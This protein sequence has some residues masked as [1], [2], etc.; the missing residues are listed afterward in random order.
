MLTAALAVVAVA[1]CAWAGAVGLLWWQQDRMIFPGWGYALVQASG[2]EAPDERLSVTAPD[3]V[4]LIGALHRATSPSRGLLLVFGGN[5]EDADWRL[6][7]FR[8]WVEDVD[9]ATFFYRGYGPSGGAPS[10][11]AL[12]ADA[13]AIHDTLVAR[14][15]PVRVVAAG[16]SLGSGVAAQLVRQRQLAGLI[17]VTPFDSIAAVASARYPYVPVASLLRHSFRSDEALAGLDIP[18]AVIG[19]DE[20]AVIAPE[21]TRRLV[22]L[23]VR[24][25]MV[26]WIAGADH[27]SI[28]QRDE[29]RIAFKTAVAQ[30]LVAHHDHCDEQGSRATI[31]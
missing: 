22:A 20:D 31:N 1:A 3:G 2:V 17:L 11:A 26:D 23:L 16:F 9:I 10:E 28:Y 8:G 5:A 13:V 27:T 15:R 12:V 19:A 6:R 25:I 7:H 24:P 4:R 29:Y 21:R 30:L 18:V 14:L